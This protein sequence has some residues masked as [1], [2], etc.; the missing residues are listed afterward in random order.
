MGLWTVAP[1]RF[2]SSLCSVSNVFP[3][4]IEG[5]TQETASVINKP[6][7]VLNEFIPEVKKTSTENVTQSTKTNG[8][9]LPKVPIP[10]IPFAG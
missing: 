10:R 2:E 6:I 3:Q 5:G 7:N 9:I 8:E 1:K 4:L